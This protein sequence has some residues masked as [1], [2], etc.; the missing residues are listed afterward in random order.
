MD[1]FVVE[2]GRNVCGIIDTKSMNSYDLPHQDVSKAMTTYID[3]TAELYGSRA[4]ELK[5]VAYISHLIGSGAQTRALELYNSKHIPV[6]LISSYG[7]NS[8]RNDDSYRV[9][10]TAVTDRLSREPVNL[11]L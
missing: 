3:A 1:V 6:S 9:N 5:F 2:L 10:S 7:L 4:L 8:L 11:I